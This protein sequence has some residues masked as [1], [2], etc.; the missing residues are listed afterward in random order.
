MARGKAAETNGHANGADEATSETVVG[1]ETSALPAI[2]LAR[3]TLLGDMRDT[4][5][6]VAREMPEAWAKLTE[7]QQR[8]YAEVFEASARQI[9]ERAVE[10]LAADTRIA[11]A[12]QLEQ[13]TFK[14]KGS[15]AKM[16]FLGLSRELKHALV[17]AQGTRVMIVIA[18][19]TAYMGARRG[20][21]IDK[22]EPPL[23]PVEARG[24]GREDGIAGNRA[25]ETLY[26]EG[27]ANRIDYEAGWADGQ[28][29]QVEKNI[30]K[31]AKAKTANGVVL[32]EADA[33]T[34]ADEMKTALETQA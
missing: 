31:S 8:H 21:K 1:T 17:D 4:L 33:A 34:H 19:A 22:Q 14:P 28:K 10:I 11:I 6:T 25:H 7:K 20:P 27:H 24:R 30:K 26:P 29:A 5:M 3:K 16:A 23:P 2:D 32:P 18:D 12:V 13:V 9:I 15:D